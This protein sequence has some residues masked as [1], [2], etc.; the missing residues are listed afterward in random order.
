MI[1]LILAEPRPLGLF[2]PRLSGLH[3]RPVAMAA[4]SGGGGGGGDTDASP[5]LC[6]APVPAP[7][8]LAAR[9]HGAPHADSRLVQV[10]HKRCLVARCVKPLH[11]RLQ[12]EREQQR[13]QG[14]AS[15]PS[16]L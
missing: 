16:T 6:T 1:W 3:P 11:H 9:T 4:C 8:C 7:A 14:V 5:A 12:R 2:R 10:Q 15:S 13:T